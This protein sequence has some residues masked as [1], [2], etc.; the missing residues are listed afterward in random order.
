MQ[1]KGVLSVLELPLCTS[2][3]EVSAVDFS[4][5]HDASITQ[6]VHQAHGFDLTD[7]PDA[8]SEHLQLQPSPDLCDLQL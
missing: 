6:N 4:R 3:Q 2:L 7:T 5:S 1:H 8:D